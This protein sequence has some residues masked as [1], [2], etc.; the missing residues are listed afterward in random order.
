MAMKVSV[1]RACGFRTLPAWL[2][3]RQ[4]D[5]DDS[6]LTTLLRPHQAT[7]QLLALACRGSGP[8]S[9]RCGPGVSVHLTLRATSSLTR[10]MGVRSIRASVVCCRIEPLHQSEVACFTTDEARLC[11]SPGQAGAGAVLVVGEGALD[12]DDHVLVS[13]HFVADDSHEWGE[14]GLLVTAGTGVLGRALRPSPQPKAISS[15]CPAAKSSTSSTPSAVADAAHDVD[16]VLCLAT[17][18]RSIEPISDPDAWRENDRLRAEAS[19]IIV[20]PAI[21]AGVAV[22]VQP[23]VTLSTCRTARSP[24][25]RQSAR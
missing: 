4:Q 24:R 9:Q 15:R 6:H 13:D 19:R 7:A 3:R 1:A 8:R 2:E 11:Q 25:T 12:C 14:L 18:I 5:H 16:A 20:D 23:T 22:Y 10:Q 21:A 17:R